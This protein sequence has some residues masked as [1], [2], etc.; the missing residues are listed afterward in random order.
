MSRRA[1]TILG[2]AVGAVVTAV[3]VAASMWPVVDAV[4]TGETP[5]YAELRP[6]YYTADP[7]RVYDAARNSLEAIPRAQLRS[8]DRDSYRLK[9]LRWSYLFGFEFEMTVRVEPVT[10]FV[11]RVRVR[12]E[13][14]FGPGDLGQNA[15][16][17]RAFFRVLDERL[18]A[19]EFDPN[20]LQQR[21]SPGDSSNSG[22]NGTP[23]P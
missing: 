5:E 21:A 16:N 22:E 18:G 7:A 2:V 13:S 12:S 17:I 10:D 3:L 19:V 4:E 23:S 11:T 14:Q 1:L 8:T 6:K 20:Q 9:A 15:R